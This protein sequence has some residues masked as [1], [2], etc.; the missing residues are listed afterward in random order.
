M[1]TKSGT[2]TNPSTGSGELRTPR[3]PTHWYLNNTLDD[4]RGEL[5][6]VFHRYSRSI[7]H[8][9]RD[10]LADWDRQIDDRRRENCRA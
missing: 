9:P 3:V 4:I 2:E 5:D 6:D 10:L 7:A 8:H 1:A